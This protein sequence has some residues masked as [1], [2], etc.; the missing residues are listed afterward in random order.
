M[1]LPRKLKYLNMFNDGLSYMGV[2]D[3]IGKRP[4]YQFLGEGKPHA[5]CRGRF[6]LKSPAGV[7][8]CRPS[9]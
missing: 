7:C 3:R 8:R 9:N 4:A 6:T 1:A 2:V 5:P